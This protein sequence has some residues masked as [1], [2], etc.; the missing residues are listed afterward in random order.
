M[1]NNW[2]WYHPLFLLL[3]V[4]ITFRVGQAIPASKIILTW[5]IIMAALTFFTMV[6]SHGITGRFFL[7][8]LINEQYRMS[9][10]RLQMFLWTVVVLS[11]FFTAVL[12]N[13][14]AGYQFVALDIGIPE[15]L[16]IAMGISTTAL[17]A[18]PL[19]LTEKKKQTTNEDAYQRTLQ[20][21]DS[22]IC[23]Q[24]CIGQ[25]QQNTKPEDARLYNLISG[26]EVSNWNILDLS[27]LQN[28]FITLVL[29]TAYAASLGCYLLK[30]VN[31]IGGMPIDKFP[32][33]NASFIAL[34]TISHAGYLVGKA[35][36]NQPEGEPEQPGSEPEQ[37]GS[38]PEPPEDRSELSK[39]K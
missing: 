38:E 8:W 23:E 39:R 16:W 18:S 22:D 25:L 27:R 13:I 33:L 10:S 29:V 32:E 2:K 17:V 28:L 5:F 19:I 21:P 37:P 34:L 9:L 24:N 26:E 1:N 4:V 20:N 7:G 30:V 14:N 11:A 6:A 35:V 3:T 31:E 36:P 12:A 15:E